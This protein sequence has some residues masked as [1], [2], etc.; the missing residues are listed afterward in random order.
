YRRQGFEQGAPYLHVFLEAD[1]IKG[2]LKP[3]FKTVYTYAHYT[4]DDIEQTKQEY[5]RA[6]LCS[7][8]VKEWT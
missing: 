1:E 5:S 8:F 7:R 4:G 3:P 2:E 6:H